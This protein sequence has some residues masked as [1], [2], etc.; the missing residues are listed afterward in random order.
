MPV[1]PKTLDVTVGDAVEIGG[2]FHDIV[3]DK[4]GG[5]TLGPAITMTVDEI[6]AKRG[7]RPLTA[8]EHHEEFGDLP[9]DVEG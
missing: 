9:S 5:A 7:A 4:Q 8:E 6:L 3:P 1:S 2:Q